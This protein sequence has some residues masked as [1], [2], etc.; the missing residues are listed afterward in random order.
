M[1]AGGWPTWIQDPAYPPCPRGDHPMTRLLLQLESDQG[2]PYTWGDNGLAYVLQCESH[3]A[4][5]TL[6][7]QSG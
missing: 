6:V 2:V 3:P 7:W 5:V 1:K 4:E